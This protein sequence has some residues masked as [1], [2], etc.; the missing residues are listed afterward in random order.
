MAKRTATVSTPATNRSPSQQYTNVHDQHRAGEEMLIDGGVPSDA[1][2]AERISSALP[3]RSTAWYRKVCV[4][5]PRKNSPE[6][7][8]IPKP[9]SA[10]ISATPERTPPD[11]ASSA[12]SLIGVKGVMTYRSPEMAADAPY[13]R[14][15]ERRRK[16]PR[17]DRG[18]GQSSLRGRRWPA[19]FSA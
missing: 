15:V 8:P 7:G 10:R 11:S 4:L 3:T 9:V 17:E 12:A 14:C 19:S 13:V 1:S 16:C 5:S 2:R 18:A 6:T